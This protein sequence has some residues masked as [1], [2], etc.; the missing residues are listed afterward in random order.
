ML[1]STTVVHHVKS[2]RDLQ[3]ATL[4]IGSGH[5]PTLAGERSTFFIRAFTC[6]IPDFEKLNFEH[7]SCPGLV[8]I[9]FLGYT[10]AIISH[11]F[12]VIQ[13]LLRESHI[14]KQAIE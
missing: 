14:R 12:K 8:M 1:L 3:V 7:S 5:E 13:R 10:V 6:C 4:E 2:A 9:K 11:V